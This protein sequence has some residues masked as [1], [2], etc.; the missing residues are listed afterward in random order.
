MPTDP[1]APKPVWQSKT[2]WLG[3]AT[4]VAGVALYFSDP[5][6][7]PT[8]TVSSVALA[9]VG[10]TN[11]ILRVWFTAAPIAGTPLAERTTAR[12]A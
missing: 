11:V 5:A 12:T 3:V 1:T 8:L 9:V 10:V 6:H 2:F 7:T 4:T